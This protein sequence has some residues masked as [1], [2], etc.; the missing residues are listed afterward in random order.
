[1]QRNESQKKLID[2]KKYKIGIAVSMFNSDMTLKMLEGAIELLRMSGVKEKNV[3]IIRVPGA[4]ELPL[5]CKKIAQTKKFDGIVAIGCVI[6]GETDH[7]QFI[8]NETSRGIMNVML[9]YSIPI[10]FGV[11]TTNTL[12]QAITRSYGKG[13]KGKEAAQAVLEV[14]SVF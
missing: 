3:T 9:E 5:A 1:M 4:F 2:G 12:E 8:A 13:N 14:L 10:G 7:Y 6:R 11:I